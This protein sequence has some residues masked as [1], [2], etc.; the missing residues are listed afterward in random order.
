MPPVKTQQNT[1][2]QGM[3]P[4]KTPLETLTD[5][6]DVMSEVQMQTTQAVRELE[7]VMEAMVLAYRQSAQQIQ[8]S[9]DNIRSTISNLNL[10]GGESIINSLGQVSDT[11]RMLSGKKSLFE[12]PQPQVI[13][14]HQETVSELKR[15]VRSIN[16]IDIPEVNIDLAR[17]ERSL[18]A[19]ERVGDLQ[20]PL[21]DGRV[22]VKLS[23]ADIDAIKKASEVPWQMLSS[24]DVVAELQVQNSLV[25]GVYNSIT[26]S[27]PS[28]TTEVYVYKFNGTTVST[29]T[30]TY[31]DSTKDNVSSVV[32]S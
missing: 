32:R 12:V 6:L 13:L 8:D 21:Q 5:S 4:V 30:V 11:I 17:I 15:I 24:S 3:S 16:A 7:P 27:Y 2:M 28:A 29:V 9:V 25:P 20:I 14:D 10:E 31:T 19:I 1:P 18:K 22:A 23:K 26:A